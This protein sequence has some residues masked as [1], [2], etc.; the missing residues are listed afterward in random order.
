MFP[1]IVGRRHSRASGNPYCLQPLLRQRFGMP[2]RYSEWIPA[3]VGMTMKEQIESLPTGG[4]DLS[5]LLQFLSSPPDAQSDACHGSWPHGSRLECR[6]IGETIR[7]KNRRSGCMKYRIGMWASAGFLVAGCW[8]LYAFATT[9]P[10]MTSADPVVALVEFTCP[11]VLVGNYFHFGVS[12][13][14]SF[15]ANAA[16]YALI[17]LILETLRQRLNQ[18]K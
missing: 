14:W 18:A 9:P 2:L 17:G 15:L 3:F 11:V 10:A 12:L 4:C 5:R 6:E 8:A 16:T 13:Y 7:P 1:D